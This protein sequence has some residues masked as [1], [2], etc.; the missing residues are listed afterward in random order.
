MNGKF[1]VA[2]TMTLPGTPW[3]LA[4]C[5]RYLAACGPVNSRVAWTSA[6]TYFCTSA[7]SFL[8]TLSATATTFRPGMPSFAICS[9]SIS[10]WPP[11]A[12]SWASGPAC[13]YAAVTEPPR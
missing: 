3:T 12:I 2:A 1:F 10:G 11:L 5:V 6:H 4:L 8:T 9:A 7:G 13:T